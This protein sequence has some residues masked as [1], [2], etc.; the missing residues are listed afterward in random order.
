M[1]GLEGDSKQHLIVQAA[2]EFSLGLTDTVSSPIE[3]APIFA[4]T[5]VQ[6]FLSCF[7]VLQA[8]QGGRCF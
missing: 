1:Y 6:M 8:A 7:L 5:Q 2:A 3:N 4:H